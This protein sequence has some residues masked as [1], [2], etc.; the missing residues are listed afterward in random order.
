MYKKLLICFAFF[1]IPAIALATP[2]HDED[3]EVRGDII[4]SGTV[5]G[6]DIATDVA[7]NTAKDTYPSTDATKVG[8][9]TVTQAVNLDTMESDIAKNAIAPEG[10]LLSSNNL[11]DLDSVVTARENLLLGSAATLDLELLRPVEQETDPD[12]V[13]MEV[14]DSV[15]SKSSRNLFIRGADGVYVF[16]GNYS[17]VASL[18]IVP[19]IN[20]TV[21]AT[22]IYCGA[23][24]SDCSENYVA[25]TTVT[26]T[27]AGEAGYLTEPL[28]GGESVEELTGTGDTRQILID[29]DKS[30]NAN[31]VIE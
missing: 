13:D 24:A 27:T 14:G 22:G 1:L 30:L 10:T 5:D 3:F 9:I 26:M 21:T 12:I 29:T 4:V 18:T 20:G 23:G 28:W 8:H 16:A 31:F 2:D 11:S 15:V 19:P 17:G 25:G 6:V 7:A